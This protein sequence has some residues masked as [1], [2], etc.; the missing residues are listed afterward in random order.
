MKNKDMTF[1]Q[2]LMEEMDSDQ[3][4]A[5]LQEELQ[6]DI[7]DG[8]AV[9]MALRVLESREKFH[10]PEFSEDAEEAWKGYQA[11]TT[12]LRT[13]PTKK[14]STILKAA[15]VVLILGVL[16][17]AI[18]QTVQASGLFN[19]I[20]QWTDSFLELLTPQSHPNNYSEYEF[21]TDNPGLQQVYDTVVELGVTEPVIPMWLPGDYSLDRCEVDNKTDWNVLNATF[22]DSK[23]VI[24]MQVTVFLRNVPS[25]LFKDDKDVITYETNGEKYNITSNDGMWVVVWFR[26]NIEFAIILDCQEEELYRMVESIYSLEDE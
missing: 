18:P 4:N 25:L 6:K 22:I 17:F 16:F 15:S 7:P 3:L 19:R 11:K 12:A 5:L 21:E 10:S 24:V 26:D 13:V 9:R 1:L 23:N 8:D 2:R 20:V 14:H